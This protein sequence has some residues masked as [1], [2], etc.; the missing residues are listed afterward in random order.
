MDELLNL[1]ARMAQQGIRRL[2]VLSGDDAC[3]CSRRCCCVNGWPAMVCGWGRS[4]WKR[5]VSRRKPS[6]LSS[7][8][9]ITTPSLMLARLRRG[10]FCRAE[11]DVESGKLADP[12]DPSFT[13]WPSR[14]DADSLR[15]SDA[16]EPIPTPHFVHRFVSESVRIL[17]RSSGVRMNR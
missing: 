12:A 4:L 17:R 8:V 9:S 14:P 6:N 10:G 2:L 1:T 11:R 3:A 16:P 13:C 15:W 7:D 5:P